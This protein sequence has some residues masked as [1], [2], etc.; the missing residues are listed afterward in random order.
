MCQALH[1]KVSKI[2]SFALFLWSTVVTLGIDLLATQDTQKMESPE[3][4]KLRPLS[5]KS[6]DRRKEMLNCRRERER[7]LCALE[8]AEQREV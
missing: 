2:G 5:V 7:E 6:D 4:V 1:L 3:S 8:M